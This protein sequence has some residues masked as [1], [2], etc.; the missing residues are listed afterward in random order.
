MSKAQFEP[1]FFPLLSFQLVVMVL[2][3]TP[4][5][6]PDLPAQ[7][8]YGLDR[9]LLRPVLTASSERL[10]KGWRPCGHFV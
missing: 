4:A 10:T 3:I 9:D 7:D 1:L 5:G 2:L 8:R 6:D